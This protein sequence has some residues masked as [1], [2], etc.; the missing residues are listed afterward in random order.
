MRRIWIVLLAVAVAVM[1]FSAMS[2]SGNE[3]DY[4]VERLLHA[5]DVTINGVKASQVRCFSR[6]AVIEWG[7]DEDAAM[8]VKEVSTSKMYRI[9]KRQFESKGDIRS[10]KDFFLR[11]SKTSTRSGGDEA[12]MRV[13]QCRNRFAYGERRV[14]LVV[15][16]AGYTV[17]PPLQNPQSDAAAVSDKL[18]SLGFDV[19]ES[20]DC[21]A[22]EFRSLLSQFEQIVSRD[23]YQVVLFYYAGHGIQK[24][25]KN[26]LVPV[27]ARLQQP[28]DI[29]G[30]IGCDDVIRSLEGTSSTSRIFIFDACRNVSSALIDP[31][32]KGLAQIQQLSPG[33]MLIYSTGF[34]QVATDG[35][36]EHSPFAQALLDNVGRPSVYFELEIK[37]VASETY[38]LTAQRQ[39]PAI[40][41]SLTDRLVL[42]PASGTAIK[43]E[44]TRSATSTRTTTNGQAE[45]LIAQGKKACK[46]FDY[47]Q[48]Y[49]CFLEAAQSG[50]REGVYQVGMLY[51]NDNFDGASI[52]KAV[53]WL[54]RAA[55]QGHADA[56]YNLGEIHLGRDNAT[57]KRW[58]KKAA[59]LGHEKAAN[60]YRKMR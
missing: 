10:M 37:D 53:E 46:K 54:T 15:G 3:R 58:F 21:N 39:Y 13:Q 45:A 1:S 36:G 16:N 40:A 43:V 41:G 18:L 30:C 31:G 35:T 25:G 52:D 33:T 23:R 60:R 2:L 7:R 42:N 20:Y 51:L 59:D 12:V 38:R 14:A 11:T 34:S 5:D 17:L 27:E 26:Y 4:L 56:M 48:A 8:L 57:A 9:S 29:D 50:S 32:R 22:H 47:A 24:D 6:T 44:P 28:K 19:V 55:D 49:K